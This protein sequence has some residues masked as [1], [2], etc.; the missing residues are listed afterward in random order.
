MVYNRSE[1]KE[2]TFHRDMKSAILLLGIFLFGSS[3]NA[4]ADPNIKKPNV[5][6]QFYTANPQRLRSEIQSYLDRVEA[7]QPRD[8]QILIAP[9]AGY[10]YSGQVAAFGYK[11]VAHQKFNTVV[12]LAPS[13]HFGFP[14]ISVW[15][16]GGLQTPLG[17]AEVDQEFAKKLVEADPLFIQEP[18]AFELEHA[19]EVEVPFLQ[20]V[21][22]QAKIVPV[23]MGQCTYATLERVAQTLDGLIGNRKDVLVVV[24]SDMS[25]FHKDKKA[26]D[27]D[28]Q[29]LEL[30]KNFQIQEFWNACSQQK[31]EMCG[32]VPVTTAMLLAQ[33]RG[34]KVEVLNY[35]NSGDV[36]G[37]RDRVVGY[38]SAVF[39]SE[40]EGTPALEQ[41]AD[42]F[43]GVLP[44]SQE[45][46]A[47]LI[48]IARQTV[49]D[50]VREGKTF[51][52]TVDDA[53]LSETEGAFVTLHK[54]GQLRGCI[55]NIIGQKPL[56]LTVRDMAI[57]AA[58]SDPRF[59]PVTD[60]ELKDIDIEVSVLSK[61]WV[62]KNAD[63][64]QM[65]VHGVIV[66]RG[67][68]HR[69]VFLPQVATET[70]WSR[71]EFLS[72]LCAQKAGLPA[73]AWKDP[74]TTLEL[75]TATVF[76]EQD[77]DQP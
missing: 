42:G 45:Q 23:I 13:H 74:K 61:P 10:M 9:H 52:P 63:E 31:L 19:L 4:F 35:A 33:K 22:P 30:I 77:V 72:Q 17:V 24:S 49:E 58:V 25:H 47:A 28:S 73:N 70:G 16:E 57:A 32:F 38:T 66:S 21:S 36:T 5:A 54:H 14:G 44:L 64:I 26:R 75:F 71:E 51:E 34:L 56:Y 65:G 6:G 60:E 59:S 76:S 40:G 67:W 11:E 27:L 18:R 43:S 3:M 12:I 15:T 8:V 55:G 1:F 2:T 68:M 69:G 46:K 37:D 29:T 50:Y 62:A 39:F 48:R 41:K 53:R 20:V 7:G